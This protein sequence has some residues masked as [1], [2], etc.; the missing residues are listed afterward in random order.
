MV[1]IKYRFVEKYMDIVNVLDDIE[2]RYELFL[3]S[4]WIENDDK[5]IAMDWGWIPLLDFAFCMHYIS[6][7]LNEEA[8]G[9][10]IFEFTESDATITILRDEDQCELLTSL[11][12][13]RLK[14]SFAEFREAVRL[15]CQKVVDDILSNNESLKDNAVFKEEMESAL[16]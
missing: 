4:L 16:H 7:R 2:L 11:S 10:E 5:S 8:K 3:G 15:F 9:E 14:M 12:G 1:E 13:V 6:N